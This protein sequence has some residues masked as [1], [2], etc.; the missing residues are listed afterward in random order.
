VCRS[1]VCSA[2]G[3]CTCKEDTHCGDASSGRV[4]DAA[5][6]ACVEGC[7]GSGGNGC[8][9]G[10]Q[11]SSTTADVGECKQPGAGPGP[12]TPNDGTVEGSGVLTCG[13]SRRGASGEPVTLLFLAALAGHLL[14]RRQR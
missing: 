11:C 7:R 10:L 9:S 5:K 14:R 13:A 6:G 8:P 3:T 12:K 2:E 4:C 1:G